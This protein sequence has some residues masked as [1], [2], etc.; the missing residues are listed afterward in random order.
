[1]EIINIELILTSND[2]L[3]C[4]YT[5]SSLYDKTLLLE[6]IVFKVEGIPSSRLFWG[7]LQY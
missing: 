3:T 1:M 7:H 5:Y 4:S 6:Y 2:M